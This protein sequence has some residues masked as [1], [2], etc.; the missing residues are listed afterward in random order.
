MIPEQTIAEVRART[1]LGALVTEHVALKR[2]G[3]SLVGLCPFHAEKT[4]SFHVHPARGFFYCFGCKA[5]GD[6]IAFLMRLEGLTFLEAVRRLAER[7]GVPVTVLDPAAEAE[8][9]AARARTERLYAILDAAAG[10]YVRQLA[11]HPLG[12]IA[13]KEL[14]RRGVRPATAQAFRLGYAPAGWDAL[15]RFLRERGHSPADAEAVGLLVPRREGGGHYDRFRHRLLFPIAD[16]QGRIVAFSGRRLDPP[17]NEPLTDGATADPAKYI[18]SPESPLYRKGELLYGLFEGRVALRREGWAI[19]CEGNFDLLALHQAGF[20]NAVAP[21]GTALTA[22]HLSTLRRHVERI[23]LLFDSDRAGKQ[24]VRAAQ[25]LLARAALPARVVTLPPGH[26]PDSFLREQGA[27]ALRRLIDAA[28]GIAEHLIDETAAEAGS[29]GRSRAAVVESLAPLFEAV[30]SPVERQLY[31][32]RLARRL[33]VR[34]PVL[35][36]RELRRVRSRSR[37]MGSGSGTGRSVGP[38]PVASPSLRPDRGT[39]GVAT[40]G[41]S[42]PPVETEVLGA[43]LDYPELLTAPETDGLETLLTNPELRSIFLHAARMVSVRGA[44]DRTVL[45]DGVQDRGARTWLERRLVTQDYEDVERARRV[46]GDGVQRLRERALEERRRRIQ[47]AAVRARRAGD[48]AAAERLMRQHLELGRLSTRAALDAARRVELD[49][50]PGR[51]ARGD[52]GND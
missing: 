52:D 48:E 24:A 27:D 28:P 37:P 12:E 14:E 41:W 29:E 11:E 30:E 20:A 23:V 7:A 26:D 22:A 3:Q 16:A 39:T 32:E 6:A 33:D 18:N 2:R 8:E 51:Q 21:M 35:V 31:L 44:V 4:P 40:S 5:Q 17:P 10:F 49:E 19:V 38:R 47:E 25:P 46:V 34:D 45:A 9:R 1:D 42:A 50:A 43:L 15:S 13:R 36:E